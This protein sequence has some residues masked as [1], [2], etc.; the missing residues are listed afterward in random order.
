MARYCTSKEA[1]AFDKYAR[2]AKIGIVE[3][4]VLDGETTAAFAKSN[5]K[6]PVYGIDPI[7]ADSMDFTLIGSIGR[8]KNNLMTCPNAVFINNYSYNVV[9]GWNKPFDFIFIDG[10]HTYPA[11]KTDFFDWYP[12]LSN[13]G[14]MAIH[15][16]AP[17]QG[18]FQGWPGPTRLV[19]EIREHNLVEYLETVDNTTYFKKHDVKGINHYD[20]SV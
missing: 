19:K 15:D 1:V 6:I 2:L 10:D 18:S 16:S 5:P 13:G 4:G 9:C 3:I 14:I 8:I 17:V 20:W 12:L 11:V 7:V